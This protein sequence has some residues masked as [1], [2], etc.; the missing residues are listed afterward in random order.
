MRVRSAIIT[1]LLA[2]FVI[3]ASAQ[4]DLTH[5]AAVVDSIPKTKRIDQ[6][7]ISPDGQQVAAIVEGQ[8]TVSSA[9]GGDS[10]SIPLRSKQQAREV[11]W[12]NDSR[13][14]A[15]I[16]DLDSDVPQSD[17]Y[18]YN[19]GAA[20][21][22]ASLKGYVQTPRFSPDGSKLALL[23]IEDLPRVAGPLQPMTPLAGVIDEKVY[24]QRITTIDVA[25]KAIK[26]VTPADV[27]IYEYDWLPDGSGW[28]A[29][30][31]HGS[32]D[33][34]WWIA[35]LYRGDAATGELHEIYAPKL[36]LAM[37]RV[38]PDGKTVVFIESLMSDEDVV[39]G[40][41]Y[42]VPIGG[43]EARNLT[44]GIKT[45]P[46]SL[47][48]TKDG[49]ILFGQN[50]DGESGFGTVNASGEIAKLW[51]G[52]D[53]VSDASTSGTI[54]GSFSADGA[55]SAIVRQSKSEAP[56]IW[57]GAIGKWTKLTSVNEEAQATWG[58]SNSVHWMN[59]TQRIQGW[60]TAPKEVK[61]GEK[62]PL[63]IS[64]HGGPSA[65]C[66][67]SWDVHYAAP[68]SLMGYYVLCPNP[69]GS[70]GQGEAFT[71]ANVKDFGG[72]DYHDIVSAI[73]ALAK[74]YPIDTKRVGITG[75]SYGGYM[76]MWAESQ[77]TRFAAAV[78]G[79]GLSHWLSYYGLNDID[80]WMIP[81]FGASVYDDP[82][83]YLKSDPMHFVKQVKT[84]T[85]ILV[86]DRDGEVPMEQSVEWWHAL[87]TFNVPTTLVVYPNEGHAI[88]K[89]ADR[90]DYAVRTAAWFE[91]WF[92]KVK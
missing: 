51:Q 81:F 77:T 41:I 1:A 52:P 21:S 42:I 91:E 6:V 7:A 53:E 85:L 60:L 3:T 61:Q 58:K 59:G 48:W 40:D 22:I 46:A 15:I 87:K 43:G 32:G 66:K 63:V 30:A 57:V 17:I 79:A 44:P 90:R 18:L 8:L 70:Y 13:Q 88:G 65:S 24:E 31:A 37:P 26:Q 55:L 56:E 92:A 28:A 36:Q 83:V 74:E 9:S 73:D 64:V 45:S 78:S 54:G 38:S 62:Y 23:F 2:T 47:R 71:R 68:L 80:E 82:A 75:H 29:I 35:R 39:G 50:V 76:T 19:G 25:S 86:G 20:K 10:R 27:Y 11:A 34:N 69:R 14:L 84:P 72:G 67:N 4:Q 5:A 16:G 33:N 49:H 89:P 12:S